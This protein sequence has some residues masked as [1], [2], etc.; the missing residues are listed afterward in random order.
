M[1][2]AR[3]ICLAVLTLS[4]AAYG[5]DCVGMTAPEQAMQCCQSMKCHSHSVQGQDCC[6]NM[7]AHSAVV[8]QPTSI[9]S[10]NFVPSV[11]GAMSADCARAADFSENIGESSH[12]PPLSASPPVLPLRL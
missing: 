6:K 9:H 5:L 8:G 10:G 1:F 3:P 11:V 7:P 2:F 4:L 12:D